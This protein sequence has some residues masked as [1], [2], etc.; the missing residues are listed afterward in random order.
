MGIQLKREHLNKL[1]SILEQ[2]PRFRT[3]EKRVG[4]IDEIFYGEVRGDQIK[5]NI[6]LE[7]SPHDA[8]ITLIMF[9]TRFGQNRAGQE[10]LG[11]LIK[12]MQTYTG[13]GEHA[14]FLRFMFDFYP[15]H[16]TPTA[17]KGIVSW[18]GSENEDSVAEKIIGENTL[19]PIRYLELA[20]LASKAVAKIISPSGTGTGFLVG[21]N[22][23][24]T[25]HH[26]ISSQSQAENSEVLFNYQL[27]IHN[28][29]CSS[30]SCLSKKNGLFYTNP[31]QNGL[32]FTIFEI[33]SP[34]K[35][36]TPL[37]LKSSRVEI[38]D[39]V[40]II[41]HPGGRMK[42]F[43]MQNN[44]VAFS[45]SNVVQYYTS[46]EPGSSGSPVFNDQFEVVGIHHSGGNLLD[47][48]LMRKY[49]RN[50]G[51]SMVA[52]INDLKLNAPQIYSDLTIG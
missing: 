22:L 24:M 1:V 30:I 36:Y 9:L 47:T 44:F 4:F 29:P 49:L 3:V 5:A 19:R 12:T 33:E 42:E 8:A 51:S 46:T 38:D 10:S 13:E 11:L 40:S 23:M 2:I 21:S 16:V 39:R 31:R 35:D 45:D 41:Q 32:D 52:I 27:D 17:V 15:L 48:T 28:Q 20:L 6:A 7:G 14:D 25:N 26:V 37:T 43:S 18:F 34:P 50:G